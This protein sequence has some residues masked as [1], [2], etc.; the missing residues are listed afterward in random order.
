MNGAYPRESKEIRIR[1]RATLRTVD[2]VEVFKREL[3][4]RCKSLDTSAE[5]AFWEWREFVKQRLNYRWVEDNHQK[6]EDNADKA[7]EQVKRMA[8]WGDLQKHHD[9]GYKTVAGPLNDIQKGRQNG[10]A[11]NYTKSPA[12]QHICKVEGKCGLIETMLFLEDE[13]L[14]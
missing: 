4:L 8:S 7:S 1:V 5:L 6:L 11:Q 12:F 2:L 3:E 14:I 13:G 9:P 10:G